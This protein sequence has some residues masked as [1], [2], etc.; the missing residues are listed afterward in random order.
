MLSNQKV[1][2]QLGLCKEVV[3]R[4]WDCFIA[5]IAIERKFCIAIEVSKL[6]TSQQIEKY[7]EVI[8]N[9]TRVAFKD[10]EIDAYD[11]LDAFLDVDYT[12]DLDAARTFVAMLQQSKVKVTNASI[13][14]RVKPTASGNEDNAYRELDDEE[15]IDYYERHVSNYLTDPF[16]LYVRDI[17]RFPILTSDEELAAAKEMERGSRE[18]YEKLV[19]SNLRLVISIAKRYQGQGLDL[20]DLI[21][22]GNLGLLRKSGIA[23]GG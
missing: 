3:A 17:G 5:V 2:D 20:M 16:R 15:I 4:F 23:E 10:M 13:F 11:I 18:A 21:Q 12:V 19:L 14:D 1:S 9:L 22:E 6:L 7:G 8:R